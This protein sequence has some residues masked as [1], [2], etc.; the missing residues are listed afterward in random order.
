MHV[1]HV[2]GVQLYIF[3]VRHLTMTSVVCVVINLL[4]LK[5]R[6]YNFKCV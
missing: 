1:K 6:D 4:A 3:F 2:S 5:E